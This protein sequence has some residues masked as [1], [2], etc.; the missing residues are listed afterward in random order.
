METALA[1]RA[2]IGR[3]TATSGGVLPRKGEGETVVA[4]SGRPSAP[5]ATSVT[6]QARPQTMERIVESSA[7]PAIRKRRLLGADVIKTE[8]GGKASP[9]TASM[10]S[11]GVATP[12]SPAAAGSATVARRR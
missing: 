4:L 8:L 3:L 11:G 9:T 6:E 12:P 2:K 5:I 7:G 1:S 10:P